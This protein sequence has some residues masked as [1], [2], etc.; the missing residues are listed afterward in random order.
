MLEALHHIKTI[1]FIKDSL[2]QTPDEEDLEF[3]EQA[4]LEK[5][6]DL[7]NAQNLT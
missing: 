4:E 2:S 5:Q 3:A 7:E 6:R 1:Q